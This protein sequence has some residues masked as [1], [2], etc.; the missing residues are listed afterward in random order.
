M[1]HGHHTLAIDLDNAMS[2]SY[3]S[4]LGDATTQKTTYLPWQKNNEIPFLV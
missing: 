2:N 4:T 1:W 3:S